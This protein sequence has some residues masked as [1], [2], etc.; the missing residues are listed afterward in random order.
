MWSFATKYKCH[1]LFFIKIPKF[2]IRIGFLVSKEYTVSFLHIDRQLCWTSNFCLLQ[3]Y[4]FHP[5][6]WN[7]TRYGHLRSKNIK[8]ES[9]R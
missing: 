8:E 5:A 6:L 1:F 7:L 3:I 9:V 2:L 4:H